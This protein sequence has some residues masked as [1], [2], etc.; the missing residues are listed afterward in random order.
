MVEHANS[1]TLRSFC[2]S[3][4]IGVGS[5]ESYSV[6]YHYFSL[7]EVGLKYSKIK[8]TAGSHAACRTVNIDKLSF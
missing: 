7:C 1:L 4:L 5:S 2:I 8:L 6:R 3:V